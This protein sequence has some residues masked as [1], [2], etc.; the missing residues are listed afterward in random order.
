MTSLKTLI[1]G[2]KSV[3]SNSI[4]FKGKEWKSRCLNWNKTWDFSCSTF[5]RWLLPPRFPAYTR[6]FLVPQLRGT[7][8]S[9]LETSFQ[10]RRGKPSAS[11]SQQPWTVEV[12]CWSCALVPPSSLRVCLFPWGGGRGEEEGSVFC[13]CLKGFERGGVDG[14]EGE[15]FFSFFTNWRDLWGFM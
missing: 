10:S 4:M 7:G 9:T 14:R 13:V 5:V 2:K 11:P 1:W 12:S 6:C 15:W 8:Q 3:T